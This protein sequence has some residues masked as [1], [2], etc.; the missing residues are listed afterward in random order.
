MKIIALSRAYRPVWTMAASIASVYK[1]VDKILYVI[2]RTSWTGAESYENIDLEIN[3]IPDPENKITR[4]ECEG[5]GAVNPQENQFTTAVR[6]LATEKIEY[7][8]LMFLDTDEVW[9][10]WAWTE[11]TPVLDNNSQKQKP[12]A[13]VC[14]RLYDYLK[15][16]FFRVNPPASFTPVCFIHKSAINNENVRVRGCFIR[17]ENRLIVDT[18]FF[19]HF[20]KVR[21]SLSDVWRKTKE[22]CGIEQVEMEDKETW[23]KNVWNKLPHAKELEPMP[24]YKDTWIGIKVVDLEDLPEAVRDHELVLAWKKYPTEQYGAGPEV[25][26]VTK[27]ELLRAG[28]PADFGPSHADWKIQSKQEKYKRIKSQ[29]PTEK[30]VLSSS[31]KTN[32]TE[33]N[34]ITAEDLVR[35]G[36]PADFGPEHPD[37]RSPSKRNKLHNIRV[38]TG[39]LCIFTIASGHYQW[40]LPLW[41][42]RIEKELPQAKPLAYVRGDIELPEP[43]K[44]K[45]LK[46]PVL[47]TF[48]MDGNTT[49]ALRYVYS[50]RQIESYDYTLITD[51]DMLLMAEQPDLIN[52]HMRAMAR[53]GLQCYDN[54]VYTLNGGSPVVPGVHFV[55]KDWWE[56][57]RRV[58]GLKQQELSQFGSL[59]KGYDEI[60]LGRII[61][62]SGL[63]FSYESRLWAHHGLHLGDWRLRLKHNVL[64]QQPDAP[65][66]NF[67]NRILSEPGFQGIM[68]MC[69]GRLEYLKETFDLIKIEG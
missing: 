43:W 65:M 9:D 31:I 23:V 64:C 32:H 52:Q 44:S 53:S 6:Y 28:L 15:S 67:I 17:S 27:E 2:S 48:P 54:Y 55:T 29:K 21:E 20:C 37:W 41:F 3:R 5:C 1:H 66:R 57:T 13:A 40:Y 56:C 14:C 7:D 61:K 51:C 11:I 46:D 22:S 8:Y 26:I 39:S 24:K 50:N 58:R 38:Y 33:L 68:D 4:I 35:A 59:V 12:V 19:H 69:S 45:C 34:N 42:D 63:P 49:A 62:E 30:T 36:L 60:M 47:D 18:V 10:D 25:G 16:P